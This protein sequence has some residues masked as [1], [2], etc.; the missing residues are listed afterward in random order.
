MALARTTTRTAVASEGVMSA[1]AAATWTSGEQTGSTGPVD[2]VGSCDGAAAMTGA[3]YAVW[4]NEGRLDWIRASE[5]G[6]CTTACQRAPRCCDAYWS[7]SRRPA[8]A[9]HSPWLKT[10]V[11][12]ASAAA[13]TH[14]A[15]AK[16]TTVAAHSVMFLRSIAIGPPPDDAS[17]A[18]S[19]TVVIPTNSIC[20]DTSRA[21]E[22]HGYKTS[23]LNLIHPA[24]EERTYRKDTSPELPLGCA[25]DGRPSH[26]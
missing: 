14:P 22:P 20:T 3:W 18:A 15:R 10:T 13:L 17:C 11:S 19:V 21:A 23:R 5:A 16:A 6:T 2:A 24:P 4:S 1:G 7:R 25:P 12:S 8:F 9:T 26:T